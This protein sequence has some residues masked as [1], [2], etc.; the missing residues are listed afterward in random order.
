MITQHRCVCVSIKPSAGYLLSRCV[1]YMNE[2]ESGRME[3]VGCNKIPPLLKKKKEKQVPPS[4]AFL[5]HHYRH[6]RRHVYCCVCFLRKKEE[7]EQKEDN[8]KKIQTCSSGQPKKSVETMAA[9][10]LAPMKTRER[11]WINLMAINH[12]TGERRRRRKPPLHFHANLHYKTP[13]QQ[14]PFSFPQQRWMGRTG[15]KLC[16]TDEVLL[17]LSNKT[18]KKKIER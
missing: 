14:Q 12:Q 16:V 13:A 6:R 1:W 8:K 18:W 10:R 17:T 11:I 9:I 3:G 4:R 5:H 2:E 15:C 7:Q